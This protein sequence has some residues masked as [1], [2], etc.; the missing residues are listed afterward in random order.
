MLH[1]IPLNTTNAYQMQI[2]ST[3]PSN[4]LLTPKIRRCNERGSPDSRHNRA[5]DATPADDE[6]TDYFVAFP[7]LFGDLAV[8]TLLHPKVILV[9]QIALHKQTDFTNIIYPSTQK[10]HATHL[11]TASH[12]RASWCTAGRTQTTKQVSV[13]TRPA[14]V[15]GPP[16]RTGL[17][18]AFVDAF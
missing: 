2:N 16:T 12:N 13:A 11:L 5:D 6:L 14:R 3:C 7:L 1:I 17:V 15:R 9:K 18:S 4:K 10:S 8:K